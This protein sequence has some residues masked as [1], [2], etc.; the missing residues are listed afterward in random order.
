MGLFSRWSHG[1]FRDLLSPYIDRRLDEH[2]EAALEEHLAT[3][4]PCREELNTLRATV[5]LLHALP[6]ALPKRSF[7]LTEQPQVSIAAPAYLWGMRAATA[8]ASLALVLLVA[9]DLLGAF[10]RSIV[11]T[12]EVGQNAVER[13][14]SGIGTPVT[15]EGAKAGLA[16]QPLASETASPQTGFAASSD[17]SLPQIEAETEETLP[18]TA[19]E[20]ALGSLLAL[21]ALATLFATRRF[22]RRNHLA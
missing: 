6:H 14:A 12:G 8:M 17:A 9:G 19:V 18:I 1:R 20:V 22:K 4:A 7:A 15:E 2:Q 10:S 3:C 5:N 11:P 16:P 21:L 13:E